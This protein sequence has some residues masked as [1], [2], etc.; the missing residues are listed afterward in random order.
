MDTTQDP[1]T[2]SPKERLRTLLDRLEAGT[3]GEA[4]QAAARE[5]IAELGRDELIRLEEALVAEGMPPERMRHLCA[6]HAAV[7]D[8][9]R[10]AFRTSLA[11][12]HPVGTLMDEHLAILENLDRLEVLVRPREIDLADEVDRA[13]VQRVAGLGAT[14]VGAEPHHQREEQVLFPALREQGLSG[15]PAVMEAEHVELRALKHAVTDGAAAVLDG[16]ATSW[17]EVRRS[18]VRLVVQ[19][20]DHIFKEDTILY[21]MAVQS[22]RDP[23][24]WEQMKVRCDAIGYC[25]GHHGGCAHG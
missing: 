8:G 23:A 25:C 20:R 11:A 4:A 13:R 7:S 22:I 9:Q 16:G 14:L 10:D 2:D 17:D 1:T 3:D 24:Q 5:L 21:P 15:P 19:L 18:A 12:G 6:S